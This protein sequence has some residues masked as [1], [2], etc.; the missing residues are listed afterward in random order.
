[1]SPGKISQKMASSKRRVM[2]VVCIRERV[3]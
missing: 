3:L 2:V 1:M